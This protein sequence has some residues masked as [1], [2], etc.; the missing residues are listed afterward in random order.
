M[1]CGLFYFSPL[2]D[3]DKFFV[4]RDKFL[5]PREEHF[6]VATYKIVKQKIAQM[7]KNFALKLRNLFITLW[8]LLLRSCVSY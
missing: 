4:V 1:L 5:K 7:K 6:I 2:P 3:R 8:S